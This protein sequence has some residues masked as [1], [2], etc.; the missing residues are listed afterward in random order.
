MSALVGDGTPL[1]IFMGVVLVLCGG[2]AL[3]LSAGK[4][5]LPHDIDFLRM[6][7]DQLCGVDQCKLVHFM[8]HDRVSFGGSLIAIGTLYLWLIIFPLREG[9]GWAWWVLLVSCGAGFA[10]FLAYLG[11]GY[12]DTWHGAATLMLLPCVV[13]G[14]ALSYRT[15]TSGKAIHALFKPSAPLKCEGSYGVGRLCIAGVGVG[16]IAG[17]LTIMYV[18]MTRVFVPQDLEFLGMS[19]PA[20]AA[21]NHNL[22]PL[23]AH[24]RAGFGGG[25]ATCG[26]VILF[27]VVCGQPSR[28]LWEALAIAGGVGFATAI[29]VHPIIGYT[30]AF[31]L[32]PAFI[33]LVAFVVGMISLKEP[34]FNGLPKNGSDT[35]QARAASA[36]V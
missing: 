1:L 27:S 18:G 22:V 14:L 19:A 30:N 10:S 4:H 21:V 7:A 23:I 15:L 28:S 6:T 24:D 16:M 33:G 8:F 36:I 13:V 32:A 12:L 29:G 2:F 9:Q 31:H 25:V 35:K 26:L 17:G 20:I 3:F 34:M 5:F 11:Y